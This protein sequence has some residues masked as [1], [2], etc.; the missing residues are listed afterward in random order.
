M[1]S[2]VVILYFRLEHVF[3]QTNAVLPLHQLETYKEPETLPGYL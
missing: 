3:E 1:D 2:R